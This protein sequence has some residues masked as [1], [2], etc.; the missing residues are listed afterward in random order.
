MMRLE[1]LDDAL[2]EPNELAFRGAQLAPHAAQRWRRVVAHRTVILE[3]S[4]DCVLL[5]LRAQE[6]IGKRRQHRPRGHRA[7]LI[8]QGVTGAPRRPEQLR[9]GEELGAVPHD[10]FDAEP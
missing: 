10:A 3:R 7:A 8:A 2:E 6:T 9:A 5:R 1:P 4:F